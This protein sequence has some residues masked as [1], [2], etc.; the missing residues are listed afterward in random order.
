MTDRYIVSVLPKQECSCAWPLSP[1]CLAGFPQLILFFMINSVQNSSLG[2]PHLGGRQSLAPGPAGTMSLTP[3]SLPG[4]PAST[5]FLSPLYCSGGVDGVPQKGMWLGR[6]HGYRRR[7]WL[8]CKRL[9]TD[10][11]AVWVLWSLSRSGALPNISSEVI[12]CSSPF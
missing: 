7:S 5:L 4:P 6:E 12:L 3:L 10:R 8:P 1:R 11:V 2:L 9:G